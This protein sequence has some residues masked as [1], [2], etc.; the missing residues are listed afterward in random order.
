MGLKPW[1]FKVRN[2]VGDLKS[3]AFELDYLVANPCG[4][5]LGLNMWLSSYVSEIVRLYW[6][7]NGF[8]M[9]IISV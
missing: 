8:G 2:L 3:W 5:L 4:F 7:E 1:E 9:L 6:W